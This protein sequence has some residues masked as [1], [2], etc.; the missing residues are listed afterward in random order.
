MRVTERRM[1]HMFTGAVSRARAEIAKAGE[2]LSSGTRV[3]RPSDDLIAWTEGTRARAREKLSEAHRASFSRAREQLVETERQLETMGV[4]IE[5]AFARAVEFA[6]GTYTAV[7][8]QRGAQDIRSLRDRFLDALNGQGY[9]GEFLFGGSDRTQAPFDASGV[10]R[11][12]AV[13]RSVTLEGASRQIV[14]ISGNRFTAAGGLD[15]YAALDRFAAALDAN[16]RTAVNSA[17]QEMQQAVDQ[18]ANVRTDLGTRMNAL[19]DA[20]DARES[21]ELHL[22]RVQADSLG[23]DTIQS[24]LD[25][26]QSQASL[27]GARTVIERLAALF[28]AR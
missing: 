26:A 20:R 22:D 8:L 15:V 24:A 2:A 5:T 28:Q 6:N 9:D 4:Q 25:L 3:T 11:G 12:D 10:Y 13:E 23:T 18:V 14:T 1:M 7:D 16:D 21:L 27:E 17:V 19:D